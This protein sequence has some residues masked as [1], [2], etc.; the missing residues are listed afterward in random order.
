MIRRGNGIS[1][2]A[3]TT[4]MVIQLNITMLN[5]NERNQF[6]MLNFP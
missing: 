5:I 6:T 4:N 1:S 2:H 3:N